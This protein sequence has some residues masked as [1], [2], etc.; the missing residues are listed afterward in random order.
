M[1][2]RNTV[3]RGETCKILF[4]ILKKESWSKETMASFFM[5]NDHAHA[6]VTI[7][8]SLERLSKLLEAPGAEIRVLRGEMSNDYLLADMA[9]ASTSD[10][11]LLTVLRGGTQCLGGNFALS[12]FKN[13]ISELLGKK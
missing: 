10:I 3:L 4:D 7:K 13:M 9:N 2:E 8:L 1:E 6:V 12:S 5:M 11:V